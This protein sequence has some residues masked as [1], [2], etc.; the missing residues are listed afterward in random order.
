VTEEAFYTLYYEVMAPESLHQVT[1]NYH[2]SA[3]YLSA[4]AC[5]CVYVGGGGACNKRT[6]HFS[7]DKSLW[8]TSKFENST[9]VEEGKYY[10]TI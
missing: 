7:L 2:I 3:V 1:F 8:A 4:Y 6:K 5:V 9:Y 10:S